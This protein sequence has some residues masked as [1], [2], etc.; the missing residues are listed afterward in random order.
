M[1]SKIPYEKSFGLKQPHIN[2]GCKHMLSL[3]IVLLQYTVYTGY[4]VQTYYKQFI[5]FEFGELHKN[6]LLNNMAC[7]LFAMGKWLKSLL[8]FR[9]LNHKIFMTKN[10][11]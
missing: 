8:N 11:F 7:G 10:Y 3:L 4:N 2:G 5:C 1:A 9:S 6:I